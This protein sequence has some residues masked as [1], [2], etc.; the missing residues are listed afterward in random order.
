MDAIIR[1]WGFPGYRE[2]WL[3]LMGD[4]GPGVASSAA[5]VVCDSWC[6]ESLDWRGAFGLGEDAGRIDE[7]VFDLWTGG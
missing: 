1:L 5:S 7:M 2:L 6:C 4:D 3:Q